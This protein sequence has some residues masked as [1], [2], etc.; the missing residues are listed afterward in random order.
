MDGSRSNKR[1]FCQAQRIEEIS[2]YIF[3]GFVSISNLNAS[4]IILPIAVLVFLF[5]NA[6]NFGWIYNWDQCVSYPSVGGIVMS[7]FIPVTVMTFLCY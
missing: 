6:A 2:G 1:F 7:D 3:N 5:R 4:R